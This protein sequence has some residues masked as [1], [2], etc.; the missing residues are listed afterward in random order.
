MIKPI[1]SLVLVAGAIIST[2]A[3]TTMEINEKNSTL[4][5][6]NIKD[7]KSIQFQSQS[8]IIN[9]K[10]NTEV[11]SFNGLKNIEFIEPNLTNIFSVNEEADF[12]VFPNPIRDNE[13]LT[14]NSSFLGNIESVAIYGMDGVLISTVEISEKTIDVSSLKKG[15]YII[16]TNTGNQII[17]KKIIKL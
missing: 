2:C 8:M 5:S 6:L 16:S 10:N 11:F 17:S 3:Q 9:T 1:L 13:K 4:I 7:I 12:E 14:L 15:T